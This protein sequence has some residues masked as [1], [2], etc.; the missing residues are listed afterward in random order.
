M[1]V[2]ALLHVLRPVALSCVTT[3]LQ[4]GLLAVFCLLARVSWGASGTLV[5]C[6]LGVVYLLEPFSCLF[7]PFITFT[8]TLLAMSDHNNIIIS[9]TVVPTAMTVLASCAELSRP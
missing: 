6:S 7:F 1:L 4:W 2:V 3:A 8:R 5:A 9:I